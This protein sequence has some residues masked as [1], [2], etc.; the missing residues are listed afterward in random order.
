M[1]PPSF[2]DRDVVFESSGSPGL[3]L[4]VSLSFEPHVSQSYH[5]AQCQL[6][7]VRYLEQAGHPRGSMPTMNPDS[8]RAFRACHSLNRVCNLVF[9]HRDVD[10]WS[11]GTRDINT[12]AS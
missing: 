12:A 4:D 8:E 5:K 7:L 11:H 9:K 2:V 10:G 3:N 6:W 1:C